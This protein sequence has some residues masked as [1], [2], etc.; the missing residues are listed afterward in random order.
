V[1]VSKEPVKGRN[2]TLT[3]D[4]R[5]QLDGLTHADMLA[6]LEVSLAPVPGTR[7][8]AQFC[9]PFHLQVVLG[10]RGPPCSLISLAALDVSLVPILTF[11]Y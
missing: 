7:G 2:G 4:I 3:A 11:C 10:T 5:E 6:E 9:T 1:L 8:K